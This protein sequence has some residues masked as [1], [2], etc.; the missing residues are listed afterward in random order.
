MVS[1]SVPTSRLLRREG[2]LILSHLHL[3]YGIPSFQGLNS[4]GF[5]LLSIGAISW[6]RFTVSQGWEATERL[7]PDGVPRFARYRGVRAVQA[8]ADR[9]PVLIQMTVSW[10]TYELCALA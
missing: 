10:S 5:F 4:A 8:R 7:E 3:L 1:I 6:V 2:D 9:C